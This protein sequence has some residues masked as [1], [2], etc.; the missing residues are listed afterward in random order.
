VDLFGSELDRPLARLGYYTSL[1][2]LLPAAPLLIL[3]L[4]RPERFW[5]MLIQSERPPLPMIKWWSPMSVGSWALLLF[6][7]IVFL[8]VVGALAKSGRLPAPLAALRDGP[9][10]MILAVS[11][12]ILGFFVA[13]Y[14]GV[15][16]AVTNR[17][18][19][20]DTSLLGLLFLLSAASTSAALLLLLVHFANKEINVLHPSVT[21]LKRM[22]SWLLLLELV[23]LALMLITL[24]AVFQVWMSVWGVVLAVGVVLL[25]ILVPL[26]LHWRPDLLGHMSTPIAAALVLV[27]GFLLRTAVVWV[28]EEIGEVTAWLLR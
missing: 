14:T 20:A 28:S 9:L 7:G 27:G 16:L 26:L 13:S 24:G 22:D 1:A 17:P 19:W 21:W 2:T 10:K 11:G 23:V 4:N 3:D 5:H 25:G 6:G 12:G 15:L 8:T 18:L